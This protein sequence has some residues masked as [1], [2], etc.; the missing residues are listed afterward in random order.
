MKSGSLSLLAGMILVGG[1]LTSPA[2]ATG[3]IVMLCAGILLLAFGFVL[4]LIRL[5]RR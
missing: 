5:L 4:V 3:K 2:L 1:A